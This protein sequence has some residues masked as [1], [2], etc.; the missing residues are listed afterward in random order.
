MVT[1]LQDGPLAIE[2][3]SDGWDTYS[4]GVFSC[5]SNANVDH[6]VLLIGYTDAYWLVKNQWGESWG[7]GGYIRITRTP[8]SSFESCFIGSG[9]YQVGGQLVSTPATRS[10]GAAHLALGALLAVLLLALF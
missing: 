9:V 7:E 8:Q 6:A 2:I 3:S 5:P 1:L 10:S 4:S